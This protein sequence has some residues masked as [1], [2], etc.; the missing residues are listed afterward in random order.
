[1]S[2]YRKEIRSTLGFSIVYI[3]LGHTGLWVILFGMDNS[4]RLLG[5]PLHYL[6]AIV[7]GSFGVL[8]WSIIW[9]RYANQL[10]DEIEA[11]NAAVESGTTNGAQGAAASSQDSLTAGAS[12]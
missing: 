2:A 9:C 1:M 4:V 3:L 12:V 10:E 7:L 5:L 8:I 6:I 11:E